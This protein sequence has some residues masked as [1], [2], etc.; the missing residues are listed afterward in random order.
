M[1]RILELKQKV[2]NDLLINEI[3]K[4][5]NIKTF[6]L[7]EYKIVKRSIDARKKE[8]IYFSYV[9][10][11]LVKNE[12][13]FI[14]KNKNS[15]VIK[16]PCDTYVYPN[17]GTQLC[18]NRPIIIGFGPAGMF[19][20]LILAEMGLKPIIF[21]RG[22]QVDQRILDVNDFWNNRHLHPESNIQFGEGGAGT[23]SDGKLTTRVKDLRSSKI[24]NEFVDAGGPE[25]IL[26]VH[27]PH[28]GTDIL[29]N[30][31]KRIRE[32]ITR[33]GGEIHFNAKLTDI[34]IE[35]DKVTGV[36][37][38]DT[39]YP[40]DDLVLAIGH[41]ARDTFTLLHEK[42]VS[43]IQK[44]FAVGVRIEHPQ[45]VIN[46]SQFGEKYYQFPKLES[47]EYKLTYQTTNNKSVYTFCMCPGGTVVPAS[48]E[49]D[50]V[51]TNGMSEYLR[52]QVNA[53][54]A[55]VCTVD[56][57]DFGSN[58]PLAGMHFQQML[59]SKAFKLGGN[60]YDAPIQLVKDFLNNETSTKLGNVLP[61]Y[62]IGHKL[63]NLNELFPPDIANALK[64]GIINM[65]RKLHNFALGDA[66]LT[67]VETRTSSPLRI[68]RENE[69][70]ESINVKGLYPSG[71]GAGYAGGI[72]SAAIDGIKV[73]EKIISKYKS[74]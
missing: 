60:N 59:E 65:N 62:V 46:K 63:V 6:D 14:K 26:Y 68:V 47:A 55:L 72:M 8:Q 3:C 11:V 70:L 5:L 73:A 69:T 1:L 4:I 35:K 30:V 43:L 52:D 67:G 10:D 19:S 38:N 33:L 71:E 57:K 7:I 2:E 36:Y 39:Y 51:V 66:L 27:N 9:I 56:E 31:V 17:Y 20:A 61:S 58:H 23:F 13:N 21:E 64:E 18:K 32:K 29:V 53:N 12:E 37:V 49:L 16:T 42:K 50:T 45:V 41:S 44:A 54:S 28:I 34:S 40:V 25:E 22:S 24:L 74:S 48:S 15:N